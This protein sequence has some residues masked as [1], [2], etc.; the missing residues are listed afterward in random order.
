LA[1]EEALTYGELD[2]HADRL[3]RRLRALGV[4]PEVPVAV[5]AGSSPHLLVAVL[6]TWKA[7]GAFVPLDPAYPR[8]RLRFVLEDTGAPVVLTLAGLEALLPP[9]AGRVV[10]LDDGAAADDGAWEPAGAAAGAGPEDLAYVIYTS[11]STGTPKGVRVE[12]GS[13]AGTLL[14]AAGAFGLGAGDVAPSLA[15]FAFDIWLFETFAPLLA[16]GA[17]RLVPRERVRDVE[18]LVDELADCTTLHAVPALMREVVGVARARGGAALPRLRLAFVGGDAVPPDLLD[19]VREAFPGARVHVLYG[20][21]EAAVV[22]ASFAVP[23]EGSVPRRMIGRALPGAGLH[24]LDE[25]GGPVPDGAAGELWVGGPGVARGYL[26][27]PELTAERFVPDALSGAAGSRLYRTGDRVSRLPD[28]ALEFLGRVDQQV[29]VRGFRIEPG[30][31]EGVLCGHPAV[32]D[33]AVTARDDAPGGTRLVGYVVPEGGAAA[34]PAELR[35]WLGERLPEHMVPSALVVLEAFPLTPTGKV[36][37]RALPAPEAAAAHVAPRTPTEAL[38]A[39]IWAD[40]LGTERVGATDDFFELGGHSLLAGRLAARV[41]ALLG[42]DLP[43]R[44]VFDAPTLE[45]LARELDRARGSD[46]AGTPPIPA[47]GEGDHPLSFAQERL[48]VLDALETGSAAYDKLLAFRMRGRL[49]VRAMRSALSSLV[50]RHES[51]RTVF[52]ATGTRPVQRVLPAGDVALPAADLAALPEAEREAAVSRHARDEAGRGWVLAREP[53]FRALLLR[54]AADEHVLLLSTHHIVTDGWSLGVLFRDLGALYAAA[55]AGEAPRLPPLP[56]RYADYALWQRSGLAGEALE[57]PLAYWRARLA[58]APA[59][60][61]LPADR[62]RPS[63]RAGRG[64]TLRWEVPGGTAAGL[65]ALGRR[66]GATLFMTLLAAWQLLLA[67]YSGQEDVVVGT[68]VAGR[69]R[70]ELEELVGFFVNTLALRGDLSD[71]GRTGFRG[72]LARTREEVLGAYAHQDLPFEKVVEAL[73]VERSLAY[74]PLFQVMLVLQNTPGEELRLPG[75]TLRAFEVETGTAK[76]DL[77]LEATER[78]G[79]LACALEYDSA[80]F[81]AATA[82]RMAAHLGVL[83]ESVAA[84][85]DRGIGDVDLLPAAE[86]RQVLRGWNETA[87]PYPERACVHHLAE[88]QAARTPEAVAVAFRGGSLTYAELD[89]RADRLARFLVRRGVGPDVPVGLCVE[90]SPEMMVGVLGILKAGGA[91]LPLDPAYPAERLAF[92]LADARIPVLLTQASLAGRLP[93]GAAEVVRL[94]AEWERIARE[95]GASP[96]VPVDPD[97][98]ACVFYTSGSTGRPKGVAMTHR[99]LVNLVAW[100]ESDWRGPRAAATLQF[101]TISFDASFPEIFSAWST[102]GR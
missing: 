71:S 68:P 83:L 51:L 39:G 78:G 72:L 34:S 35:A 65:R 87:R 17:V 19:A 2:A 86:R 36:D 16:G 96:A 47:A 26:G 4:G 46:S 69:T 64:R 57:R 31:V 45:R 48:W 76:F 67:R 28:G 101:A 77:L 22:C 15:S 102:G 23:A 100:Q 62:P 42:V 30:E 63:V 89:A 49:D 66:E 41:R 53:L 32:R 13:L 11:G 27:R 10:L 37:R 90:R 56:V 14:G 5:C 85:P 74:H 50:T 91:Y 7:G 40:V 38:L 79:G 25:G 60:L 73:R 9:H 75:L 82:E 80:L 55:A 33:A 52:P 84:G 1:G 12:H 21:T 98:L 58:G 18:A 8:E 99:P 61:E 20:P 29:K 92:M 95:S 43:V 24:V 97:N 54:C 70:P 88:R 93:A 59:L 44:A 81:D 94:D 3:A 6:A